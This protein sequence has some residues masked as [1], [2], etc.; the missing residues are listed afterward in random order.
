VTVIALLLSLLAPARSYRWGLPIY[1]PE[2][3]WTAHLARMHECQIQHPDATSIQ[4]AVCE[5]A[6]A[7]QYTACIEG[8]P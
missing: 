8:I 7:G 1:T 2:T 6:S 5:A 3:C 4:R